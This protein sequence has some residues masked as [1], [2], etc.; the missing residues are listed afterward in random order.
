MKKTR[1]A[2][3]IR[4]SLCCLR[5]GMLLWR[6]PKSCTVKQSLQSHW[7]DFG[8]TGHWLAWASLAHTMSSRWMHRYIKLRMIESCH[9]SVSW[10]LQ[11]IK[12]ETSWQTTLLDGRKL[13]RQNP[14]LELYR[15]LFDATTFIYTWWTSPGEGNLR[16][17][18]YLILC[19]VTC[20]AV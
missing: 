5:K 6:F 15:L 12:L 3:I 14:K 1:H 4:R 13:Y 18:K 17:T 10:T 16:I 11:I 20:F 7:L 19:R 2:L 8:S 9:I